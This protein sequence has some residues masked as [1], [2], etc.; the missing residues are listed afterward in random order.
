M[1]RSPA[2]ILA[3]AII[4]TLI[5]AA[6]FASYLAPYNPKIGE[7]TNR[8]MPPFWQEGGSTD[9]I[10]GTDGQ[11]R[12]V[13]SR[14]LYGART[15]LLV[16]VLAIGV[17]GVLGSLLG[18]IAGYLGGWVDTIIMRITDLAFSLP[19]I[20][21]AL[22]FAI[23]FGPSLTNIVIILSLVL[24]AP[25]ARMARGETLKIKNYDFVALAK[26]AGCSKARIMIRHILPNVSSSLVVLATLQVGT[27]IIL[28]SSLSFLGVGLPATTP[29]WGVMVS[30]GRSYIVSAWW[31][32]VIPGLA[33]LMTVLSFNLLGDALNDYLNPELRI[34]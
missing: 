28:E 22:I 27:V 31:L 1:W 7:L 5:V 9:H 19:I 11:G 15:S 23:L 10:L 34:R 2:V 18:V 12:D 4:G 3:I 20:L 17:A 6:L 26:I 30:A 16:C 25:Y 32:C 29:S 24:W 21:L 8:L 13:L 14:L 33:I